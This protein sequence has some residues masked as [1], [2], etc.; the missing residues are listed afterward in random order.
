MA[1]EYDWEALAVGPWWWWLGFLLPVG[2][3][4]AWPS[5]RASSLTFLAQRWKFNV[6]FFFFTV[7]GLVSVQPWPLVLWVQ[8]SCVYNRHALTLGA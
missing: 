3:R 1:W 7:F 2:A 5:A 8:G 4:S 6:I